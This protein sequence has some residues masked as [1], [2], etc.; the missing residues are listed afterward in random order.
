[1]RSLKKACAVLALVGMLAIAAPK[2]AQASCQAKSEICGVLAA[3]VCVAGTVA[4]GGAGGVPC[5]LVS[6]LVCTYVSTTCQ[7][8]QQE[9]G[10]K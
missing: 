3:Y 5:T 10:S 8:P 6:L 7:E 9:E 4:S 1:M 2:P